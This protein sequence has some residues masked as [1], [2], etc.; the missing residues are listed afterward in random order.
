LTTESLKCLPSELSNPKTTKPQVVVRLTTDATVPEENYRLT[1]SVLGHRPTDLLRVATV[2]AAPVATA[3]L[4][5][6]AIL[7]AE[8]AK[9]GA[10]RTGLA[11]EVGADAIAAAEAT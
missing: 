4:S 10:P 2:P 8:A 5:L 3:M 11:E 9:A 1:P 7:V 6:I